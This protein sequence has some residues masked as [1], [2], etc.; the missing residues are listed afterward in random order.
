VSALGRLNFWKAVSPPPFGKRQPVSPGPI[1]GATGFLFPLVF[2]GFGRFSYRRPTPLH[3]PHFHHSPAFHSLFDP[4]FSV[5]SGR[6][7]KLVRLGN[8]CYIKNLGQPACFGSYG[9]TA[10]GAKKHPNFRTI[11]GDINMCAYLNANS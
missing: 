11:H 2:K 5:F 6:S 9:N 7:L 4:G 3:P 1:S 8:S 10:C